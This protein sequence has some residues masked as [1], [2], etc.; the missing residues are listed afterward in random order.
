MDKRLAGK[1][2]HEEKGEILNIFDEY[3]YRLKMSST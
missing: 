3:P 1:W 2:L